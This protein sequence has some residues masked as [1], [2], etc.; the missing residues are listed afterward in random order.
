MYIEDSIWRYKYL[1]IM[2]ETVDLDDL[3][4]KDRQNKKAAHVTPFSLR[5]RRNPSGES[6]EMT[7][8]INTSQLTNLA[9]SISIGIVMIEAGEIALGTIG[10]K[11]RGDLTT[12][13]E[14]EMSLPERRE[15]LSRFWDCTRILRIRIY[16][17]LIGFTKEL[18]SS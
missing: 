1:N 3:I 7:E 10:E 12:I 8:M 2:G 17:Y 5:P 9:T 4:K 6:T 15:G 14:I 11:T 18:V 13:E 16:M